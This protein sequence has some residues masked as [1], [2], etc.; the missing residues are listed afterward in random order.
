MHQQKAFESPLR[1]SSGSHVS[2]NSLRRSS[3]SKTRSGSVCEIAFMA[4]R[5]AS[6]AICPMSRSCEPPSRSPRS[7]SRRLPMAAARCPI[8]SSDGCG[9]GAASRGRHVEQRLH[10]RVEQAA[11]RQRVTHASLR[12]AVHREGHPQRSRRAGM[13]WAP[14]HDARAL[15][16]QR[17]HRLE[18]PPH[19][20]RAAMQPWLV[21]RLQRLDPELKGATRERA[22]CD[23]AAGSEAAAQRERL[24]PLGARA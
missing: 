13:A 2:W 6:P 7:P 3:C 14:T 4:S 19:P 10:R 15:G 5:K 12:P 23:G 1:K 8:S 16:P 9:R 20:Q 24:P 17:A 22:A 21:G 11:P 18:L